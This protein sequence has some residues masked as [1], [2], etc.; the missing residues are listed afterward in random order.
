MTLSKREKLI[1]FLA[2]HNLPAAE[3]IEYLLEEMVRLGTDKKSKENMMLKQD[4]EK[5]S[6]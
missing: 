5:R 2:N 4:Y 3:A 1:R 6:E